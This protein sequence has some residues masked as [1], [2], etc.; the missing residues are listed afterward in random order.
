MEA[1]YNFRFILSKIEPEIKDSKLRA[2]AK[3]VMLA[4][5]EQVAKDTNEYR[6]Q[7]VEPDQIP[8]KIRGDYSGKI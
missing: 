2:D 3:E 4:L 5:I 6:E 7:G 1:M 8:M